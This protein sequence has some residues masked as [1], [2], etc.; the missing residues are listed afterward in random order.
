MK[1]KQLEFNSEDLL[2]S[3]EAF[4]NLLSG[5]RKLT[6]RT[7]ALGIST[8]LKPIPPAQIKSIR[9]KFKFSIEVFAA[10]L[11]VS[12]AKAKHWE[13]GYKKPNGPELRL[14]DIVNK[15]PELL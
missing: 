1:T 15:H 3:V 10:M 4:A 11:N 12:P 13:N 14:L 2:S 9:N 5:K 8:Q 6:L 7:K